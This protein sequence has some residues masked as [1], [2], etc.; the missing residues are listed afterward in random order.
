MRKLATAVLAILGLVLFAPQSNACST[1]GYVRA[2]TLNDLFGGVADSNNGLVFEAPNS[3]GD[4]Q[5]GG[6]LSDPNLDTGHYDDGH[7][8]GWKMKGTNNNNWTTLSTGGGVQAQLDDII[9]SI[10]QGLSEN[11]D[12]NFAD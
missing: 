7:S 3:N 4:G 2:S 5:G 9:A 6:N 1:H 12:K 11:M 8:F 10:E